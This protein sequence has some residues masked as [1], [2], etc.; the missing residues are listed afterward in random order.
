MITISVSLQ[1]TAAGVAQ[2]AEPAAATSA[3]LPAA[4]N[5]PG[6]LGAV[7]IPITFKSQAGWIYDGRIEIPAEGR[8]RPWAV[9]LLHLGSALSDIKT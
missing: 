7:N 5:G 9:M 8:R 6:P 1:L 3:T 4:R 2:V